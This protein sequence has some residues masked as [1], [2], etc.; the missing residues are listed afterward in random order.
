MRLDLFSLGEYFEHLNWAVSLHP[1]RL[2]KDKISEFCCIDSYPDTILDEFLER[3]GNI[4]GL[5]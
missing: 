1:H 4:Q 3:M 2:E 5:I